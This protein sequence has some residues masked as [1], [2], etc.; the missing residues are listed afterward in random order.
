MFWYL[1]WGTTV[2]AILDLGWQAAREGGRMFGLYDRVR[3]YATIGLSMALPLYFWTVMHW[4]LLRGSNVV[5]FNGDEGS[6]AVW[7]SWVHVWP[8]LFLLAWQHMLAAGVGLIATMVIR[9]PWSVRAFCL[10]SLVNGMLNLTLL[11]QFSPKA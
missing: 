6:M 5:Q 3:W 8:D 10:A 7:S 11:A 9:T 1:L 2:V 4:H